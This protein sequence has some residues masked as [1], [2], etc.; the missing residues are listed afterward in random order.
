MNM[1]SGIMSAWT[2]AMSPSNAWM[3]VWGQIAMGTAMSSMIAGIGA[4]QI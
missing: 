2:S 1:L 3:T 4:A